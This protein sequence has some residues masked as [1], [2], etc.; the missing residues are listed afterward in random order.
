MLLLNC[1]PEIYTN[2]WAS[3]S[4]KDFP[5]NRHAKTGDIVRDIMLDVEDKRPCEDIYW[6]IEDYIKLFEMSHLKIEAKYM[7]LGYP[8]EPFEWIS[9]TTIPPFVIFV[10]KNSV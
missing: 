5:E 8:D 6:T 7:P 1:T 2:E 9:E 4:T 3:F 10:L